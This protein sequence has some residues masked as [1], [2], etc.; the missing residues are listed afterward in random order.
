MFKHIDGKKLEQNN[1]VLKEAGIRLREER[2]GPQLRHDKQ[3]SRLRFFAQAL[4]SSRERLSSILDDW[5]H[6]SKLNL[7]G[8]PTSQEEGE[9]FSGQGCPVLFCQYRD[10]TIDVAIQEKLPQ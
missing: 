6:P 10:T 1:H 8:S 7:I 4:E 3:L 9:G 2:D 5:N